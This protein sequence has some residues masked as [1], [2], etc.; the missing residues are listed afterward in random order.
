MRTE[1]E[2]EKRIKRFFERGERNREKEKKEKGIIRN[3]KLPYN[4]TII[5]IIF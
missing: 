4:Y 2:N 1:N 3:G 5:M